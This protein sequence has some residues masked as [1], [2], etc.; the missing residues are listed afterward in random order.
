VAAT[1]TAER[2]VERLNTASL[3]RI[4]D[5]DRELPGALGD[6]QLV[7]DELL[8]VACGIDPERVPLDDDQKVRLS[9]AAIASIVQGGVFFE[10][11]LMAGFSLE[12]TKSR[13][14][15]DPRVTYLLHEMGEE[16]RHS[17]LFVRLLDQLGPLPRSPFERGISGLATRIA[18]GRII[19]LPAL[20]YTM[21]LAGEEIPDLFQK[22]ASEHPDTDPFLREV[23]R[24]HRQEEARHLAFARL[25]M[26]EVWRETR[27]IDRLAVRWAAPIIIHEMYQMLVHAGAYKAAGLPGRRTWLRARHHPGR[28]DL[29]HRA[30]RPVIGALLDAKALKPSRV[31]FVWRLLGRVD[32]HG[33][34]PPS[35]IA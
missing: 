30:V 11:A 10:A 18:V 34:P 31:P 35:E 27:W 25:R 6:G 20:L 33:Q 23:N 3:A 21:V 16:T 26:P 29:L 24:Y 17:R 4:I 28:L 5:P 14:Y 8:F 9:R 13:D 12:I 7:P 19:R 22:L 15:T 32:R 1:M 2:R